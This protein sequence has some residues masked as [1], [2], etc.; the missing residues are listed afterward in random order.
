MSG[1]AAQAGGGRSRGIELI[2]AVWGAALLVAP[3]AVLS[4]ALRA[5]PDPRAVV[6]AR[7]LGAR[8]L[9]QAALSGLRPTRETLMLGVGVDAIHAATAVGLAAADPHRARAALADALVAAGWAAAG[10]RDLAAHPT[11]GVGA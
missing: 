5:D 10:A 6:V 8:H 9:A 2:R 7:I 3:G 1:T 11:S 4:G